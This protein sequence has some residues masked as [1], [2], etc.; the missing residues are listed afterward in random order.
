MDEGP[1]LALE[2]RFL[3]LFSISLTGEIFLIGWPTH[4]LTHSRVTF[5]FAV[6]NHNKNSAD[7]ALRALPDA[8]G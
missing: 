6:V 5:L 8:I 3:V 2:M 7:G 1:W 4:F